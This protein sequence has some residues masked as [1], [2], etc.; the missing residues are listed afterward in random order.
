MA[1]SAGVAGRW[2]DEAVE[3]GPGGCVPGQHVAPSVRQS[4]VVALVAAAHGCGHDVVGGAGQVV[5]R[6]KG[7]VDPAAAPPAHG[8]FGEDL[9]LYA[10]VGPAVAAGAAHAITVAPDGAS[11]SRTSTFDYRT[12][13]VRFRRPDQFRR[14][15]PVA[16]DHSAGRRRG[17]GREGRRWATVRCAARRSPC[18]LARVG[19]PSTARRDAAIGPNTAGAANGSPRAGR[20]A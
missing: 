13:G 9:G 12:R 4:Q 14:G 3:A 5:I 6:R 2:W 7:L 15:S 18:P 16:V 19:P 17:S 11:G 8:F 1:G 20:L 10:P